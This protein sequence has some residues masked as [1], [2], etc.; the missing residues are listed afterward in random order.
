MG[1]SQRQGLGTQFPEW[2]QGAIAWPELPLGTDLPAEE[3]SPCPELWDFRPQGCCIGDAEVSAPHGVKQRQGPGPGSAGGPAPH[4]HP[5]LGT[6]GLTTV[7]GCLSASYKL[8][9]MNC[10][11]KL[12]PSVH[13]LTNKAL[14]WWSNGWD[15]PP[16]AGSAG[17]IPGQVARSHTPHGQ[18]SQNIKQKQYCNKFNKDF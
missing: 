11:T 13:N 6:S 1:V 9:K 18:K 17:P 5:V 8:S 7:W 3:G 14:P 10:N 12:W 15:F 4:A 2:T 16:K